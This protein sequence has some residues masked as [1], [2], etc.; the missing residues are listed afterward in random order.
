[1][2]ATSPIAERLSALRRRLDEL[3][4]DAVF[5]P[6]EDPHQ[7]EYLPPCYDR[8]PF[9][10]GFDGS[11]GTAMVGR[12][13]A[14][15]VADSRYWIQAERQLDDD[16]YELGRL[17]SK[18]VPEGDAWLSSRLERGQVL[19]VDARTVTIQKASKLKRLADKH[20]LELKM[21]DENPIDAAWSDQPERPDAPLQVLAESFAG[22]SVSSKLT[23]VREALAEEG[24]TACVLT[25]LDQLAWLFNLRGR[26]VEYNPV[27]LGFAIVTEGACTLFVDEGKLTGEVRAA[28]PE[29]TFAAYDG[30]AEGLAGLASEKTKVW[31][32]PRSCSAWVEQALD[33]C[34]LHQ[35]IKPGDRP[36][37][38][39]VLP[40][41]G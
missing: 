35:A 24:C 14:W 39:R 4:L 26:D 23:R 2:I 21:L 33:G 8:R 16:L 27:F 5:V 40:I 15:L 10:S 9:I 25:T 13:K 11:A 30:F 3:G 20:G 22:E 6:T 36:W 7:S 28:L 41:A 37:T 29:V 19:G 18:D 17:G 1:M 12:E 34:S 31:V 32:D 38:M